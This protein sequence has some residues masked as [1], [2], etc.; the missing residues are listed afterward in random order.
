MVSVERIVHYA[1]ELPSEAAYELLDKKPSLGWPTVGQ[2]EF[3]YAHLTLLYRCYAK[4]VYFLL[5]E[6]SAKYRPELDFVLKD[7]SLTIVSGSQVTIRVSCGDVYL[8]EPT[9]EDWYLR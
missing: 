3:R 1:K 8:L 4:S 6:Y 5:S 7:I 2:V 9:R